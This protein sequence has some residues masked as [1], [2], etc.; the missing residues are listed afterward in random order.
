MASLW[1][2]FL[3]FGSFLSVLHTV[4][5]RVFAFSLLI[6]YIQYTIKWTYQ[7]PA[8]TWLPLLSVNTCTSFSSPTSV[9]KASKSSALHV[10]RSVNALDKHCRMWE[11]NHGI[12]QCP[13]LVVCPCIKDRITTFSPLYNIWLQHLFREL[14]FIFQK[15]DTYLMVANFLHMLERVIA[16][17]IKRNSTLI[18]TNDAWTVLYS[19]FLS[20]MFVCLE[21]DVGGGLLK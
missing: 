11:I 20:Q 2:A 14:Q 16:Q 12:D 1:H 3:I 6:F 8:K 9:T 4:S 13:I 18:K 10:P 5:K 7:L 21:F 15:W 17:H 19:A